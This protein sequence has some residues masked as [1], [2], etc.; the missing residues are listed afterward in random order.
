MLTRVHRQKRLEFA[1]QYRNWTTSDWQKV[2]FSDESRFVLHRVDGRWRIRRETSERQHSETLIGRTQAGGGSVM[3]WGIVSWYSLGPLIPIEGTLNRFGYLSILADAVHPYMFTVFPDG[4]GTFQQ[5]NA[6]CHTAAII[7]D[8][9]EEHNQEFQVLP[10]PP[11]SPDLNPIESL[12]DHLDRHVRRMEPPPHT[13]Q[14]LLDS[15]QSAWL[16]IP[17]TTFHNLIASLPR[18]LAAVRAAKGGYSG[19]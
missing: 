15:L 17:E 7:K 5:D 8:W 18:R 2:A 14:Q 6:P 12:W 3:V 13:L 19:Y 16:Q 11:N 4:D 1:Q 10:W 9:L